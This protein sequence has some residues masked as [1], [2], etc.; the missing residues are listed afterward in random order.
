M[1][2]IHGLFCCLFAP[3]VAWTQSLVTYPAPEGI[4]GNPSFT[5]RVR[6]PGGQWQELFCYEVEV[7]L[8]QPRQSSMAYFDFSG[9]VEISVT[10][11]RRDIRF[12]QVRPI[13]YEIT[14]DVQ[15]NT[16]TFV[17][18][19]PRNLSLEIN[20]DRFDNLHLFAGP[21]ETERPDPDDPRVMFFGPGV[22]APG[23]RLDIPSNTTVYLAGGAVLKTTLVCERVEN[24]RI[25]GRGV[26]YQGR[27]GIEVN[28]SNDIEIDGIT[29]VNPRHYT[30]HGGQSQH[31]TIRNLKSFSSGPWSDGIDLM[32]C[33]DVLVDGVFM[34]NSDDCIA[35]YG[36][37]WRF[38]GDSRNITVRN[39]T[40][41]ADVAHPIQVGTHG[42]AAQPEVIENLLFSNIDIL[43]HDEPQLDYQ[44][45]LSVNVSDENLARNIRFEDIRVE[46]FTEGQLVNLRVAYNRK[47]AKAPGRG[48]ENVTFKNLSYRGTRATPSI[49]T[50]YDESRTIRNVVFENLTINGR[51]VSWRTEKAFPHFEVADLARI[52]IGVHVDG[53]RFLPP[54]GQPP[55]P[56]P[57]RAPAP[58]RL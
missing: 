48:I 20:G 21:I 57:P 11:N 41:W 27:R 1:K 40:L 51:E 6:P 3:V 19:Q 26:L 56:Q 9:A 4:P 10:S 54:G 49:I 50:G 16:L 5:V 34:R 7:D 45:C 8:H 47:Y 35:I 17:L 37:R 33:S 55:P 32:S 52:H 53:V 14:P 38:S 31:V 15:G 43:E 12:A 30:V 39:S 44:G 23:R 25:L 24:V 28:F 18:T 2:V 22:H 42:N 13:S 46:D 36:H 58:G 29:V